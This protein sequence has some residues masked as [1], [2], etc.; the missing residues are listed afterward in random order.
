M[1]CGLLSLISFDPEMHEKLGG[2]GGGGPNIRGTLVV[3]P[4]IR[5]VI[6][7]G[8]YWDPL[9]MKDHGSLSDVF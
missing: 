6:F 2:G 3:F 9:P 4:D 1:Q 5:I 7:W 8:L